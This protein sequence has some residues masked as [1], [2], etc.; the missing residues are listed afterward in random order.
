[1]AVSRARPNPRL[2]VA[3]VIG[4]VFALH[5]LGW[6]LGLPGPVPAAGQDAVAIGAFDSS[7]YLAGR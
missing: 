4:A 6:T 5:V 3:G 2:R 1:M 7:V